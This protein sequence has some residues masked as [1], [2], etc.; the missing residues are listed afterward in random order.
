MPKHC[1]LQ[2]PLIDA[3]PDQQ[4][5]QP[6]REAIQQERGHGRSLTGSHHSLQ[7]RRSAARS[8]ICIPQGGPCWWSFPTWN[9]DL[10]RCSRVVYNRR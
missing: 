8:N 3:R 4:T 7:R 2:L 5:K 6:A 10:K 9:C 1:D